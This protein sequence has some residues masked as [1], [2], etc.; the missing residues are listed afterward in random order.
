VNARLPSALAPAFL[1]VEHATSAFPIAGILAR[2]T[3]V[4]WIVTVEW[5]E[6][7]RPTGRTVIDV[8]VIEGALASAPAAEDLVP[9]GREFLR[10]DVFPASRFDDMHAGQRERYRRQYTA[11]LLWRKAKA[12]GK[13]VAEMKP[14]VDFDPPGDEMRMLNWVRGRA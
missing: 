5:Y 11:Y 6:G 3:L 7:E 13:T 14:W 2:C 1:T 9:E 4:P 10:A 12:I 8:Q